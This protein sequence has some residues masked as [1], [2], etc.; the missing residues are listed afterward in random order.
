[1]STVRALLID[2]LFSRRTW[3]RLL[4]LTIGMVIGL[5]ATVAVVIGL[6]TGFGLIILV[7]GLPLIWG[8][9]YFNLIAARFDARL[10]RTL[11]DPAIPEPGPVPTLQQSSM[12]RSMWR[13][14]ISG[15]AWR[16]LVWHFER[17]IV[18]TV[19]VSLAAA[20][21]MAAYG[22]LVQ[23]GWGVLYDAAV[24]VRVL[25]VLAA[26]S[27][28]ALI[29][30]V[31]D[32]FSHLLV[33]SS[34]TLLGESTRERL[35]AE[36]E[37]TTTAEARVDLARDLHDSVG[38]S[39]TA[40]VLQASAARA[41]LATDP[42]FAD[43]ALA[44]IEDQGRAAL[45]ELDR[46]LATMRDEGA[47][48][49]STQDLRSINE[50]VTTARTAGQPVTLTQS[51]DSAAA[52]TAISREGYR[53]LQE[54]ITNAMR[55]AVGAPTTVA[56]AAEPTRLVITVVNEHGEDVDPERSSGG[57][58]LAG[59]AERVRILGGTLTSGPT[60]DGGFRVHAELPYDGVNE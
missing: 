10:G 54:A 57:R 39:V 55:H 19:V 60:A 33:V 27:L 32:A 20:I 3:S 1:M 11:M 2:G 22:L 45:E 12:L 52:P 34:R 56:V 38:H 53:V 26:L 18:G 25:A 49:R 6:A 30:Y 35:V 28:I 48:S 40:A 17:G 47:A 23:S 51:G 29:P 16:A 44:A 46:V 50:L 37:R 4:Y 5:A 8:T 15:R 14:A 59:I 24:W 43:Q 7:V 36:T 42:A 21:P 9:M 31:V 13:L 41:K 58:G